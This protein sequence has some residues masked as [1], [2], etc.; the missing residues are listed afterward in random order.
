M[1]TMLARHDSPV[2]RWLRQAVPLGIRRRLAAAHGRRRWLPA[3]YRGAMALLADFAERDPN[4]FHRFLWSRHLAYADTYEI[5]RR[6]GPENL[7]P[8]RLMFFADLERVLRNRGVEPS[9]GVASVFE[10]GC[11]LGYLL[12]HA[13]TRVF[14]AARRLEGN[15]ID[16]Y[17]VDE[18]RRHL[19]GLGSRV[20]LHVA[21]MAQL[22]ELLRGQ[23]F[24]VV[25]CAGVL[26]YVD[27]PEAGR[28]VGALLRHSG[29][30]TA[31]AGLAHP[32]RDN[33]ELGAPAVRPRDGAFI[34]N[35]DRLVEHAGGT[36][37]YR[38]WEGALDVRGNTI[39]FVFAEPG[40]AGHEAKGRAR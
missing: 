2:G 16:A 30:V 23:R 19:A 15:D 21:D 8:S 28:V 29:L 1:T 27:E 17:A 3:R 11:S 31:F 9:T 22:G 40:H 24:D 13:E 6:Y 32:Q 35:I 37:V 7:H 5:A 33:A 10:V 39:Y 26:M 25:F 20:R 14:P 12:R 38:R 36:V 34:H 4:G 18:G